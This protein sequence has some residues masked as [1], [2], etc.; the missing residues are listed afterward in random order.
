VLIERSEPISATL[1]TEFA[2]GP[3]EH[4]VRARLANAANIRDATKRFKETPVE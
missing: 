3:P 1:I 2:A 4:E